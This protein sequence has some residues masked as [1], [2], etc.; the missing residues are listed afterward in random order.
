MSSPRLAKLEKL[1]GAMSA[2]MAREPVPFFFAAARVTEL[3]EALFRFVGV[4]VWLLDGSKLCLLL[5]CHG[6]GWLSK[7]AQEPR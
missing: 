5:L 2:R 4:L 7:E 1:P 3:G 6:A